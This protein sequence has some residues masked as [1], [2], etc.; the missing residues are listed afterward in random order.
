GKPHPR[1]YGTFA[2]YLGE[3]VREQKAL[4]LEEMIRH[5]TSAPAQRFKLKDRG[6][7]REGYAADVVVFDPQLV[8]AR[9]TYEDGKQAAVG[10]AHV[11]VNGEAVLL[12]GKPTGAST[13]RGLKRG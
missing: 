7:L 5:M 8:A 6:L 9:A 2:R 3:Y 13:G 10:V 1:G 12:D 11:F 4:S